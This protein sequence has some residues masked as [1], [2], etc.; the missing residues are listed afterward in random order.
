[1]PSIDEIGKSK[2]FKKFKKVEYRPWDKKNSPVDSSIEQTSSKEDIIDTP[3]ANGS[4]EKIKTIAEAVSETV[5]TVD[6]NLVFRWE[7]KDRPTSELGDIASLAK[8]FLDIGQQQPCVVRRKDDKYELLIGERRWRAAIAAGVH[9]KVILTDKN[10]TEACIA[11]FIENESREDLSDFAKGM[12]LYKETKA[13]LLKQKDLIDRMGISKQ[14][15]SALLSFSK[16][17]DEVVDAIFDMRLVSSATAERIKALSSKGQEYVDALVMLAPKVRAG[18]LGRHALEKA[19]SK[20][21]GTE[22]KPLAE[23]KKIYSSTGRHLCS[24]GPD[25]NH[26]ESIRFPNDVLRALKDNDPLL[27]GLSKKIGD[28]LERELM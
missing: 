26:K 8:E 6:P 3:K 7:F 18:N 27:D 20:V 5:L 25:S 2:S 22:S 28:L 15:I 11:Q 16:I 14:K 4:G 9:L 10:D 24:I 1:M 17:P 13:G 12:S 19:V 23:S 21:V